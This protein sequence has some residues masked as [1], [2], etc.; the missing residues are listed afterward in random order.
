MP[1]PILPDYLRIK[2]MTLFEQGLSSVD[3]NDKIH[4][5][6]MLFVESEEQL[7]KCIASLKGKVTLGLNKAKILPFE[8]LTI[9]CRKNFDI[10]RHKSITKQLSKDMKGKKFENL[11]EPLVIDILNNYEGFKKIEHANDA[12]GFHNPPFDF[13]AFKGKKPYI[14]EF[15]GSIDNFHGPSE[16]QKRRMKELLDSVKGLNIALLQVKISTGEYRIFYNRQMDLFFDG[17]MASVEPIA[18]WIR[19]K[20]KNV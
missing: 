4:D 17:G 19:N 5:K 9:P 8:K 3:V 14:I 6:A 10:K 7:V 1:K 12:S 15:K 16:S 13:F 2:I 20:L 18:E 11:C